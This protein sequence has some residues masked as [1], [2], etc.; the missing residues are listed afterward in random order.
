MGERAVANSNR[1]PLSACGRGRNRTRPEVEFEP[2][3]PNGAK[4]V[5][6]WHS[7]DHLIQNVT[8]QLDNYG[9]PADHPGRINVN[10]DLIGTTT[11]PQNPTSDMFHTNSV[12]Y[13]PELDQILLSVPRLN[14]V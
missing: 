2:Q 13:N 10:G 14:E 9:N 6:E 12:A 3:P 4:I 1:H 8:S 5:W 11:P 7:W